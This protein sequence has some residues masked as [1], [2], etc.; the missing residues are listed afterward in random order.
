MSRFPVFA[1]VLA[2]AVA[3]TLPDPWLLAMDYRVPILVQD[4]SDIE[5]LY[6]RGDISE[7][8]RDRLLELLLD[9]LD[10][11]TASRDDLYDLPGISYTMA[12]EILRQRKDRPFQSVEDLS[13]I[14]GV[15]ADV[16]SQIRPFVRVEPPR[17]PPKPKEIRKDPVKGRIRARVV[18]EVGDSA[19]RYPETYLRAEA[20][21]GR[22]I[23]FGAMVRGVNTLNTPEFRSVEQ[24]DMP[25]TEWKFNQDNT[26]KS[27]DGGLSPSE[28]TTHSRYLYTDGQT[29]LPS[30]PKA[31]LL[32]DFPRTAL[33]SAKAR[34]LAGS[35]RI[36]FGQRLVLD[37]S[38][39]RHPYGFIPDLALYES[40]DRYRPFNG[41]TGVAAS[42]T[43]IPLLVVQA[44]ITAFFSWWKHDVYQYDL[45]SARSDTGLETLDSYTVL[46]PYK[47]PFYRL[48]K[49]QTLPLAMSETIGGANLTLHM[50]RRIRWGF[51]GYG[52][53][54][55]FHLDDPDTRFAPS[56]K[57]PNR[58]VFAAFGTDIAIQLSPVRIFGEVALTDLGAPA[59]MALVA[60]DLGRLRLETSYRYYDTEFDNPHSRAAA[61]PDEHL[62]NRDRGEHG[63]QASAR[64]RVHPTTDLRLEAN[65]WQHTT[66]PSG[67]AADPDSESFWRMESHLRVDVRPWKPLSVGAFV[68]FNDKD[69]SVTGRNR[70]YAED[71]EKIQF[72]VQ[73]SIRLAR[74]TTL[75]AYYKMPIYDAA[76][77][78]N[79]FQKDH[80]TVLRIA[81]QPISNLS[82]SA[83]IK[84]FR[85]ELEGVQGTSREH[86]L[87]GYL[88]AGF[89]IPG[90][91]TLSARAMIIHHLDQETDADEIFWRAGAEWAF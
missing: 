33:G 32:M 64:L 17:K 12:D 62:G 19:N 83:R 65:V 88:Q 38:G 59:A 54:I 20:S 87:D 71:G 57:F 24:G 36:G 89:R 75:W 15:D 28:T 21:Q 76:L 80:Y 3:L 18:D 91:V 27:L 11:N 4:E 61:M 90:N 10:L 60:T 9:P 41:F 35:Y 43:G 67:T 8:E 51:T 29:W 56:S 81:T 45:N 79:S 26:P 7:N 44:D 82:L 78:S 22:N 68:Q 31:Y 6:L 5:E 73:G 70:K 14:P 53:T 85:G 49:Y 46:T 58:D 52:A 42:L 55:D 25:A 72:G 39:R 86:F 77:A 69:L 2:L 23:R 74:R 16:M 13:R 66:S 84:Y 63:A 30:W 47:D 37:N 50:G 34:V 1:I 48:L 40:E